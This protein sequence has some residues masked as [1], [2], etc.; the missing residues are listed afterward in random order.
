[1]D[2]SQWDIILDNIGCQVT[3]PSL[4]ATGTMY[5]STIC[6]MVGL[7]VRRVAR[8]P[9]GLK[10]KPVKGQTNLAQGQWPSSKNVQQ[11]MGDGVT[12]KTSTPTH[13]PSMVSKANPHYVHTMKL[14]ALSH[15][16]LWS[17]CPWQQVSNRWNRVA[18]N[19]W[20]WPGCHRNFY[21]YVG[22]YN[23]RTVSSD[24][25]LFDL[26]AELSWINWTII[27]LSEV[28]L[29]SK[30]CIILNN[31]CHTVYYSGGNAWQCGVGLWSTKP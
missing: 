15:Q 28:W 8:N 3:C 13:R 12:W 7:L 10:T 23:I 19:L 14:M 29:K 30:G 25:K 26:E 21:L 1:M 5:S 16:H 6:C 27:G 24:E 22:T 9:A 31:T 4:S 17:S 20:A 18:K 11:S 2:L